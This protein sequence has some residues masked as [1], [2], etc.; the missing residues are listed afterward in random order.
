MKILKKLLNKKILKKKTNIFASVEGAEL[1]EFELK[2][3]LGNPTTLKL[4][5]ILKF[6][7]KRVCEGLIST[8]MTRDRLNLWIGRCRGYDDIIELIEETAASQ[9]DLEAL[10]ETYIENRNEQ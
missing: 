7:R 9:G 10:I 5:K 6:H 4:L 1:N 8:D 3:W 2:E